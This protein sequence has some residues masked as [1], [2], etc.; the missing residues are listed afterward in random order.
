MLDP[1]SVY[2]DGQ[3]RMIAIMRGLDREALQILVPACPAWSVR[4]LLA[5]VTAGVAD[6]VMGNVPELDGVTLVDHWKDAAAHEALEALVRRQIEERRE[7]SVDDLVDEWRAA[8]EQALPMLRGECAFPPGIPPLM[9]WTIA[10]DVTVHENDLRHALGLQPAD[11]TLPAYVLAATGYGMSLDARIRELGRPAMRL[12]SGDVQLN[13]GEGPPSAVLCASPFE[14]TM[15]L[16]G[17]RTEEQIRALDWDG[18]PSQY[19]DIF[20][21]YMT[22]L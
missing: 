6:S 5:H 9:E 2:V 1:C 10:M 18:D 21:V 3:E 17:R 22:P 15:A 16:T 7:R 13:L 12:E 11:P 4:D 19:L 8:T 20:S 14:L